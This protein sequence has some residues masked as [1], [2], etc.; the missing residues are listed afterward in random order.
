MSV[1]S[2]WFKGFFWVAPSGI[3]AGAACEELGW[4]N[5][6][7]SPHNVLCKR[8]NQGVRSGRHNQRDHLADGL[9]RTKGSPGRS[10]NGSTSFQRA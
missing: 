2:T 10:A 8:R 5:R 9:L 3:A 6:S 4:I 7:I 1:S